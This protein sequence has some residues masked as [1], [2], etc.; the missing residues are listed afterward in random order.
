[1]TRSITTFLLLLIS[2]YSCQRP[3]PSG[4]SSPNH[5]Y[6]LMPGNS[7]KTAKNQNGNSRTCYVY[8][9]PKSDSPIRLKWV[10]I[11]RDFP[12]EWD[13]FF[14]DNTGCHMSLP[15]SGKLN[16]VS[17]KSAENDLTL[18]LLVN[19]NGFTGKGHF[20]LTLEEIGTSLKDTL[21]F[22]VE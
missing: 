18:G 8:I 11:H 20:E 9:L 19:T 17:T 7:I 5:R 1:M 6:S 10:T 16:P 14:C 4:Y 12:R 22:E 13:I 15:D 3:S 21:S 2:I